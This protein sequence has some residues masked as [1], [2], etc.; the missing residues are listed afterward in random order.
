M[1]LEECGFRLAVFSC[2]FEKAFNFDASGPSH[3][4]SRDEIQ[5]L[6]SHWFLIK[7]HEATMKVNCKLGVLLIVVGSASLASAGSWL[8]T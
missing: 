5:T 6:P 3:L 2:V 4:Q 8:E 7:I 1:L